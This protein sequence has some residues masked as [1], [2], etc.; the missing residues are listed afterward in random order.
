MHRDSPTC[1]LL[2]L[3]SDLEFVVKPHNRIFC[4]VLNLLEVLVYV[5]PEILTKNLFV[6]KC[7]THQP[8]NLLLYSSIEIL[9]RVGNN[10]LLLMFEWVL[11]RL[12]EF[13]HFRL[14]PFWL[15]T[16]LDH[17]ILEFFDCL[18]F[19]LFDFFNA[20]FLH[21]IFVHI[22]NKLFEAFFRNHSDLI[23]KTKFDFSFQK[24]KE[25]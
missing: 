18:R 15:V 16:H 8:L 22:I 24:F 12:C 4:L 25:I 3:I 13:H 23:W 1:R 6:I 21:K 11:N 19:D 9:Q 10:F 2:A 14:R 5:R 20:F 17:D 7:V